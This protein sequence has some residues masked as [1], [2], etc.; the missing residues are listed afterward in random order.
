VVGCSEEKHKS[1]CPLGALQWWTEEIGKVWGR[2]E[3]DVVE[4]VREEQG[5][6]VDKMAR[7][8]QQ[9][10]I[11]DSKESEMEMEK[12]QVEDNCMKPSIKTL[13]VRKVVR[14]AGGNA[15]LRSREECKVQQKPPLEKGCVESSCVQEEVSGSQEHSV[16]IEVSEIEASKIIGLRGKN[17]K[18]L[19]KMTGTWIHVKDGEKWLKNV[20]EIRG[21]KEAVEKAKEHV[22]EYLMKNCTNKVAIDEHEL[23]ALTSEDFKIMKQ[24]EMKSNAAISLQKQGS[25]TM[26]FVVG[27][28]E[29]AR[30]LKEDLCDFFGS[31]QVL[32][33]TQTEKQILL[34]G[35]KNCPLK[36]L[37]NQVEAVFIFK[38][39]KDLH[40]HVYGSEKAR[41][42]A[43]TL[44][45]EY[46]SF[47]TKP[48]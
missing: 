35:G 31:V 23:K 44:V 24:F 19:G 16:T 34:D 45:K 47:K 46:L 40:L 38:T 17:V 4:S 11:T 42:E 43:S 21:D 14:V 25:S 8:Q 48:K 39:F 2:E 5:I 33:L 20:V 15:Q 36:D 41:R 1:I 30:K 13:K 27:P 37:S 7:C 32:L 22:N 12:E 6:V 10:L 29:S 3:Q 18:R 28:R 9:W 26:L